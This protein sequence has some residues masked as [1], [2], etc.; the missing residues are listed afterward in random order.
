MQIQY[1]YILYSMTYLL[2]LALKMQELKRF[3]RCI[4]S[5]SPCKTW[6][7]TALL[8]VLPWKFTHWGRVAHICVSKLTIIGSDNGL[9]PCQCQAII[10]TNT[11]ILPIRP[12]GTKCNEIFIK[13]HA[14]SFKKL[15]LKIVI[16]EMA[17]ILSRPQCVN[18][19]FAKPL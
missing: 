6:V 5:N 19:S 3:G 15:C 4:S 9:S 10:W 14:F 13:I 7:P 16:C 2:K 1:H 12:L 18:P 11:G 8:L 17:A